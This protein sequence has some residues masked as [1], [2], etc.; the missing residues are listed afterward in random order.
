MVSRF[1]TWKVSLRRGESDPRLTPTAG[2]HIVCAL[3]FEVGVSS[4]EGCEPETAIAASRT[5]R[6]GVGNAARAQNALLSYSAWHYTLG[7]YS[8]CSY[9]PDFWRRPLHRRSRCQP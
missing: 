2:G 4:L 7:L 3:T 1:D 8:H 6:R 5:N 9:R